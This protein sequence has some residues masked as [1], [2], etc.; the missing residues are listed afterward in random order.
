MIGHATCG[1]NEPTTGSPDGIAWPQRPSA[2]AWRAQL[3]AGDD[4]PLRPAAGD[5]KLS[6][7][8]FE[9]NGG[10]GSAPAG[11]PPLAGMMIVAATTAP[12]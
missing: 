12:A 2:S 6:S 4:R 11:S 7:K 9:S 5:R 1:P 8:P 10:R 3:R